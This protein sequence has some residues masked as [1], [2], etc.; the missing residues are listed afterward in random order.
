MAMKSL[1][2]RLSEARSV[3]S[4][5]ST[6]FFALIWTYGIVGFTNTLVSLGYSHATCLTSI[7]PTQLFASHYIFNASIFVGCLVH[8]NV[9]RRLRDPYQVLALS[10]LLASVSLVGLGLVSRLETY[11]VMLSLLGM[12]LGVSLT[13]ATG[14]FVSIFHEPNFCLNYTLHLV[15]AVGSVTASMFFQSTPSPQEHCQTASPK[16][17]PSGPHI[18]SLEKFHLNPSL[19]IDYIYFSIAVFQIPTAML[20]LWAKNIAE[21]APVP[22]P[23]REVDEPASPNRRVQYADIEPPTHRGP[24][25]SIDVAC[26]KLVLLCATIAAAA[27]VLHALFPF[28]ILAQPNSSIIYYQIFSIFQMWGRALAIFCA[29]H[30]APYFLLGVSIIGCG[31]AGC[32]F[33]IEQAVIGSI[34]YGFFQA[35][36]LP[37]LVLYLTYNLYLKESSVSLLISGH[38][39][40]HIVYPLFLTL[41]SS[42]QS[43]FFVAFNLLLVLLLVLL[44]VA[45][46]N[47]HAQ[48]ERTRG[49]TL[50]KR[51]R[52]IRP[53]ISRLRPNSYR[54]FVNRRNRAASPLPKIEVTYESTS[55]TAVPSVA[56]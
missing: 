16:F 9:T 34:L 49:E 39:A 20:L 46:L 2:E 27:N 45:V 26:L 50:L 19:R 21:R 3:A 37:S 36:I 55:T 42:E 52:S 47:L 31:V 23:P 18:P 4:Q 11:S 30:M 5:H 43:R 38:G 15:G 35:I 44:F 12:S 51:T 28:V 54:R 6:A 32:C 48:L 56:V 25:Q 24:S 17:S 22:P 53:L 7:S 41:A 13:A 8:S 10:Q 33:V 29:D 40:G 14:T 1:F